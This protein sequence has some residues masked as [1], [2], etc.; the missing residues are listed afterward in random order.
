MTAIMMH[1]AHK[2]INPEGKLAQSDVLFQTE[3][4]KSHPTDRHHTDNKTLNQGTEHQ[5]FT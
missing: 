3:K 5:L 4:K 1:K 2:R